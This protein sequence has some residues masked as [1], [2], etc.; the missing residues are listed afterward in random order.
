MGCGNT[1]RKG[2][3]TVG[4]RLCLCLSKNKDFPSYQHPDFLTIKKISGLSEFQ[5]I[6][7]GPGLNGKKFIEECILK[8]IK[9]NFST[10]V[11]DAEAL[12]TLAKM[13]KLP[14]LPVTWILTPHEGE[15]SRLLDVSSKKIK[16]N[17]KKYVLIAQKN[18]AALFYLKDFIL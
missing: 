5:L 8:F 16:A 2:R 14:K 7:V 11:L 18:S 12:N 1:L 6:A 4:S 15:L 9:L 13:K 3:I 10:V 17:R